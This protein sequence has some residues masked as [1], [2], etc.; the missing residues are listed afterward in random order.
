[1]KL[2]G[3]VPAL[4]EQTNMNLNSIFD[5]QGGTKCNVVSSTVGMNDQGK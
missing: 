1:M 4:P 2:Q 5:S 3:T